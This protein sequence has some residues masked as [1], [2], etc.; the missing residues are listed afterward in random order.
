[1]LPVLAAIG[2]G[3]LSTIVG[4]LATSVIDRSF[5]TSKAS[6]AG[7]TFQ[8]ILERSQATKPTRS[9]PTLSE[10]LAQTS[11]SSALVSGLGKDSA[12]P[13]LIP[14]ERSQ[15]VIIAPAASG[16]PLTPGLVSGYV[17]RKVAANAS[18]IDL[19]GGVPPRLRYRLPHPAG[20]VQIDVQDLQGKV[21]R[22][23][24]LGPQPAGMHVLAFDGRGLKSGR[25]VYRVS[26]ADLQGQPLAG[27]STTSGPVTE[28]RFADGQPFLVVGGSLVPLAGISDPGPAARVAEGL[29]LRP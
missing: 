1:M 12:A 2:V 14:R 10:T 25:H 15:P 28:V 26:A 6:D 9:V 16:R 8:T 19:G 11:I 20:S 22:T 7:A 24:R 17:G 13:R 21:V 27:V 18:V 29:A 4:K 5:S 23:I 3:I